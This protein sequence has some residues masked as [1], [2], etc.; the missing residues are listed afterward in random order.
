MFKSAGVALE[1][2]AAGLGA[3]RKP[4]QTS[5]VMLDFATNTPSS[6]YPGALA[7]TRPYERV[8]IIV[9]FDRIEKKA[10][11][12]VQVS[13]LLGHVMAHEIAHLLQGISRHSET[14]VMKARWDSH[15]FLQMTQE[16][17]RFTPED[18]NLIQLGL[19]SR[20]AADFPTSRD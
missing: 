20:V 13:L 4:Q 16:P 6:Q 8:H 14:G 11:G 17:L 7:Y 15:D 12:P 5:T 2:R 19:L 3:C 1:W 10:A 9:L 18:I